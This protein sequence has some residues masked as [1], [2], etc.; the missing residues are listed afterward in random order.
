MTEWFLPHAA[1]AK[2]PKRQ[3]SSVS[4]TIVPSDTTPFTVEPESPTIS[5]PVSSTASYPVETESRTSSLTPSNTLSSSS[6]SSPSR[7]TVF[8]AG[9]NGRVYIRRPADMTLLTL[10]IDNETSFARGG[11]HSRREPL[12]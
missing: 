9:C 8:L 5:S 1:G 3:C 4:I 11:S 10:R 7:T 2:K 6:S 12:A